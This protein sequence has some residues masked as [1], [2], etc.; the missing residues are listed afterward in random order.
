MRKR[1]R[2]FFW[3]LL[4]LT[5]AAHALAQEQ[6]LS[7]SYFDEKKGL[8]ITALNDIYQDK[9]GFLWLATR[10][11]LVRYDGHTFRYFRNMPDDPTSI[12][13]NHVWCVNEDAEGNIWTGLVRG[14]VSCYNRKTGRFRNY[15]FTEKLKFKTAPVVCLFF[16]R[17]GELWMGVSP[18][19]IV[20]LDK[21]TGDFQCYDLVTT[22]TAPHLT[23]EDISNYNV[24][25]DLWQ[26]ETDKIWCAT[27]DDLYCLDP[28]TGQAVSH[29]AGKIQVEKFRADQA[30][31]LSHDRDLLW[32]GG[33]GSGLRRFNRKTGEWKQF[34]LSK[35]TLYPDNENIINDII[36]KNEDEL[37]I[38]SAEK[39][40]G[41]F[42]KKTERFFFFSQDPKAH[43]DLP[44]ASVGKLLLDKQGNLWV[45]TARGLARIQFKEKHFLFHPVR[46]KRTVSNGQT[47]ISTIFEDREG[48]FCF[49]GLVNGDGLQVLDKKTGRITVPEM[50]I[51]PN[52]EGCGRFVMDMVQSQDGTIWVLAKHL[53]YRFNTR[54]MRLEKPPQPPTF[55]K[56][57]QSNMYNQFD[58]DPRGH[59]WIGTAMFGVFRYDTRTGET[60][61]FMPDETNPGAIATNVVG[62]IAVDRQG[63]AW[64]GSR[65]KTA[66]GYYIASENRFVYLDANGHPT[67]EL[68]STRVNNF[69][70]DRAGD[71]WVCSEQGL[72]HFDCSGEQL[73]LEKKYTMA[74][75]L[76]NEYIAWATEDDEGQIWCYAALNLCRLDKKTGKITTFGKQDGIPKNVGGIGKLNDGSI[77][78]TSN[79]GYYTFYP[80]SLDLVQDK[81]PLAITS[82]K[83]DD[84]E[85]YHGSEWVPSQPMLVPSDG[86]FF[87]LEFAAL[88]LSTPETFEYEYRLQGLDDQWFKA[89]TRQFVSYTNIPAGQYF[90]KVKPA[91]APDSEGISVPLTVKVPLY[92]TNLFWVVIAT[93][94][95][96]LAFLFFQNRHRQEQQVQILKNKTQLL[97]QEREKQVQA[98]KSKAQ[99]LEKEK[100]VVL[101]ES[102]KQQLNPHFLFNSLT[103]LGS[104]I[105]IDPKAAVGFLDSLGKTY[106]YILKSSERETVPL[107]EELKFAEN[108]I[109]LQKMRFE[110]GLEVHF[111]VEEAFFHR[112]IV[113]VTLQNLL[114]NAIK[115]N[116]IDEETPLIIAV[117]VENDCL[118]VR[119]NMQKKRFVETSNR[120]GLANLRSF[121]QYL[122]ERQIEIIETDIFFTI[123]IPLI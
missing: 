95:I 91:G 9:T 111:K 92:K 105:Q 31:C 14:G 116:I 15:P 106:R 37:W 33:W 66:Y 88:D 99:L 82:F 42:N 123:K 76:P 3:V 48:R 107:S 103:S 19:G 16:D 65:N 72:L 93:I 117:F 114:E 112:K 71:V 94:L 27:T 119:N 45:N 58:L 56:V 21:K 44:A 49:F 121:Y 24:A 70:I 32:I 113:P 53:I 51:I 5:W 22:Q 34:M 86:R 54:T 73:R 29:R 20:H 39:G 8:N 77:F 40:L 41:I 30:Y 97:E 52:A 57:F 18:Y 2:S 79:N 102:L 60:Q 109:K 67:K 47:D 75:G 80:D 6:L 98:L 96:G 26:D 17:E 12:A 100:A 68:A 1:L 104:L 4:C 35:N 78:L 108:F 55:S 23:Q 36:P 110:A 62:S 74:D 50:E 28:K 120:R 69:F 38:A 46:S 122:S 43:P 10:E 25:Y 13:S 89:G 61:H 63:R 64:Y 90:F 118:V 7:L 81:V 83:V 101:Y 115:H 85:Q 59:L 11:G 84:Q 87:S